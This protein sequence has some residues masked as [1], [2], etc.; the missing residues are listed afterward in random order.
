M[1]ILPIVKNP[2]SVLRKKTEDIPLEWLEMK[3]FQQF[4]DD[5]IETM[6]A[7]NG[8]GLAGNQV[9][10]SWN[11]CTIATKDGAVVLIN[12]HVTRLGLLKESEEEGCL[13]VP[14]VWGP[15]KRSKTLKFTAFDRH[16]QS[17]PLRIA[18]GL[19]ARVIQHEC[20]HLAGTLF[21]DK[22][23]STCTHEH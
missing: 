21:I 22:A 2:H 6:Y 7:A 14:G 20:D 11:I 15:V 8:I 10:T 18:R 12:P 1:P 3:D 16:G 17:F 5:M 4:L 9:G 23:T 13:S 19:F